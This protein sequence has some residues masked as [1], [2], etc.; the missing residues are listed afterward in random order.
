MTLWKPTITKQETLLC[1]ALRAQGIHCTQNPK[2]SGYFPN[3]DAAQGSYSRPE[4]TRI[5]WIGGELLN[6]Y[7]RVSTFVFYADPPA[8]TLSDLNNDPTKD[9]VCKKQA[10]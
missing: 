6:Q 1:A 7:K 4:D 5:R 9:L 10:Q 8:I 2:V 3:L